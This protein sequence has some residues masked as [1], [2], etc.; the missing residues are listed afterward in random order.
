MPIAWAI[1]PLLAERFPAL[2][3]YFASTATANDT[4]VAG[5]AG[6]GYV[7]LSQLSA[8]QLETVVYAGQ[9]HAQT[10][11]DGTRCGWLHGPSGLEAYAMY[12]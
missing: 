9:R 6:A 11:S 12:V 8:A 2:F 1:S 7:Y 10:N 4:F 5:V 3:D